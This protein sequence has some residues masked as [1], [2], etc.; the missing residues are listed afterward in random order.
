MEKNG[1]DKII[2]AE[3]IIIHNGNVVLGMQKPKRWYDLENGSKGVIIKTIGGEIEPIDENSSKKAVEREILEEIKGI[4]ADDIKISTDPIFSKEIKMGELNP[5]ERD[6][7]LVMKADFYVA[8]ITKEGLLEPKD[9][10]ALVEVPLERFIKMNFGC[11]DY[12]HFIQNNVTRNTT[13][14]KDI[15]LPENYAIMTPGEVK[16]FFKNRLKIDER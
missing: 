3:A 10:P 4:D 6:S 16:T 12:L 11:I 8:E 15:D 1:G 7:D 14:F 9:L 5:Y 2:G 13:L